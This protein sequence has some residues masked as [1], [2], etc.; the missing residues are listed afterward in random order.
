MRDEREPLLE[1]RG[2]KTQFRT[3]EGIDRTYL[4]DISF[5]VY[6]GEILALVGESGSGKSLTS[7]SIMGLLSQN[8]RVAE[9]EILFDGVDLRQLSEE[10]MDK[11]RGNRISM[12]FQDALTSLNPSF[13]VGNQI[14]ESLRVHKGYKKREARERALELLTRVGLPSAKNIFNEYPHTLSGGMRQRVMIAIALACS[15]DLLIADEAT[16]ALDVTIQAQIMRFFRE[17]RD[18]EGMSII[19][20]THDMGLVAEMADRIVVLYAGQIVEVA[21]VHDLF[22]APHHPY[23]AALMKSIP[24]QGM[25]PDTRLTTI[26]GMV[27]EDY[28]QI[29]YC[30][31]AERCEFATER[32]FSEAQEL[33]TEADGRRVRCG[34]W[35]RGEIKD[36]LGEHLMGAVNGR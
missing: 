8:G 36:E 24:H 21:P 32:C 11:Y 26:P 16:T 18:E 22:A 12:I 15:P 33:V 17:L 1:V 2:I 10:Q 6:P 25:D 23:T 29:E 31:F 27:P 28:D 9:G 4:D 35:T 14:V 3:Q 34:R 20:I 30:R 19:L 5:R 13:T 7:L